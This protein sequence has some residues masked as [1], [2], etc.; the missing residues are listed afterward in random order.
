[1]SVGPEFQINEPL[2]KWCVKA[3][4]LLRKRLGINIKVHGSD[5]H[6]QAGQIFLFNHFA[7][8][9]TIIPQYFI[10]KSTGAF[11]RCVATHELFKGNDRFAKFLWDC[12]AVPNSHPGLLAFLAAE[13]LRG[14]KVIFFPEGS[15]IKD[16]RIAHDGEDYGHGPLRIRTA[17][18]HKQGAAAL[19]LILEIY[20]TRILSVHEAGDMD[21][22]GRW[23]KALGLA[24][25]D[26]LVAAARQPTLIVP[27]N[28]TFYPIHTSDNVLR[29]AAELFGRDLSEQA[30][31][32]IL[33]EG[34][35]VLKRTD[36][37]IR[38]GEP[39]HPRM[40]W[41]F[42]DK[43]AISRMFEQIDSLDELFALKDKAGRWI[44]RMVTYGLSRKTQQLRDLSMDEM[45]TRVTVNLSHVA[46][47]LVLTL[48]RKGIAEIERGRFHRLLYL[49]FKAIQK[50]PAIH[51]HRSLTDPD[52]YDGIHDGGSPLIDQFMQS[53]MAAQLIEATPETY[54][55][56]PALL[57]DRSGRDPRIENVVTVYANELSPVSSAC[58]AI[59]EVVRNGIADDNEALA[60]HLFDD[61]LRS[62]A[63][64]RTAYSG[65]RFAE[66][67]GQQTAT[68]SGE[69][70]LLRPRHPKPL[71]VVLVHGFL[72]SPAEL[73]AFGRQLAD[74]GY[75]VIGVRLSGHGTSPWDLRDRSRQDWLGSVRRGFEIMSL[76]SEQVCVIGF[77]MGGTLALQLAAEKPEK[78]AGIVAVSTALKFK[79][80]NLIFVP[81]VH[82]INRL[83]EWTYAEEGLMPFRLNDSDHPQINYR[84][85]P[86]RGLF[87][88]RKAADEAQR[89]LP[90]VDCPAAILHATGDNVIDVA[91]STLIY[92]KIGS[93][94]KSLHL[95]ESDRHG[96]LNEDIGQTRQLILAFLEK[97]VLSNSPD[98]VPERNLPAIA[99]SFPA[100]AAAAMESD[101]PAFSL[102]GLAAGK[103]KQAISGLMK[104]AHKSLRRPPAPE[105]P[106]PKGPHAW[107]KSYP[108]D[109]DW[110]AI[111]EPK[112][113]TELLDDAVRTYADK[114]CLTFRRKHYTY[115]EVGRLVDRAAKGLQAL[116]VGRGI[117]VGLMLPNCPYAVICFYAVLKAGGVVVNINPLY[118]RYEIERQMTDSDARFLITLD[119]KGLYEKVEGIA[120][121]DG[122]VEKLII[123]RMRDVL[124]FTE[125]FMLDF[126]K[127]K[128]IAAIAN[129]EHHVFFEQLIDNDG[130]LRLLTVDPK[131]EIA[132]LQYTGGTTG[133]AKGA[134]LSHANLYVNA[135]QVAL[136]AP[137][138]KRGEEKSLAVLPLFHSFGMTAIMNTSLMIGAEIILLAK[139]QTVE[140]LEA[141]ARYKPTIFT[142]V[143]TMYS[144]LIGQKD[145]GKYNLSSLKI[146]IS[147]GAP[148]PLEIQRRFESLT[149]CKLV[150][151]YGL[152]EASPVCTVN[153]IHAAKPGSVG[154][155][156]PGTVIE[157]VSLEN[158]DKLVGIGERGEVCVSGPQVMAGYANR[159]RENVDVFRGNRLHTGDV[160]YLDEDGYLYI[161]D[162]I[163]DLILSSGFN[164]YPRQVEEVIHM[165][166]A[167][168]EV[169][170]CGVQDAHRGEVVK[171][172]VKLRDGEKLTAAELRDFCSDKL[173][174]F[175]VPRKIEFRNALPKTLIGKIS[176]KDLKA[177]METARAKIETAPAGEALPAKT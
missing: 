33:I 123:C 4:T 13:I 57:R 141:I 78:L 173:A 18:K 167:V 40:T 101:R 43:F 48:L 133:L 103:A 37:D 81:V 84:H 107:Q 68:E 176:K 126:F 85:M 88:L 111:I 74:M 92:G 151:G 62:F 7:R 53:A 175:E 9:E 15:M 11:C 8:F 115:R 166:P 66:I 118:A 25:I 75:P 165:H 19:A 54:R 177:E 76:L 120:K 67:N 16:R 52:Y 71:G 163:K 30:K 49:S 152:S 1:M 91:S 134:Q 87:E 50:D 137:E 102:G 60:L 26:A 6:M 28:I 116:G 174:P 159:A 129:D 65:E 132:V 122:Q 27:A 56:Q 59:D 98:V 95:I 131:T 64:A 55:F 12:G 58:R 168:E 153:P 136:W 161:V 145:V 97:L 45:Y 104:A 20:K 155:P 112:P 10:Y 73:K 79:N 147:G 146:C 35:L 158:P 21:R 117:K 110:H 119:V 143:P 172:F 105:A 34:N 72:A 3:F 89:L 51:L 140:V 149:G 139:F 63:W 156:L 154:L 113:L 39:I 22:L 44:E 100:V 162:R 31:E 169:A 24:G 46:S 144:A 114:T 108:K 128:E 94:D 38:F 41:N 61:K 69:P 160:G 83:T 93:T 124:R 96:I 32:E 130:A 29:K 36:M 148:L 170:V 2:Y 82:G 47:R 121:T 77:S 42:A 164:V 109:V 80:R 23:V 14:R 70:Y 138:I 17:R 142:G 106:A 125:K 99:A 135:A 150:E 127:S 171:A 90:A 157:I 86:V 5:A